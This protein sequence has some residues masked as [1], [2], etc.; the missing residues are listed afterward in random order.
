M[1]R[2]VICR[3]ASPGAGQGKGSDHQWQQQHAGERLLDLIHGKMVYA[4]MLD[5]GFELIVR[6]SS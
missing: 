3:N 4:P 1:T 2:H 5:L 6:E